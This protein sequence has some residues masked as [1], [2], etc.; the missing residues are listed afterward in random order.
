M[1]RT[2]RELTRL[3]KLTYLQSLQI[4]NGDRPAEDF[5]QIGINSSGLEAVLPEIKKKPGLQTLIQ[6]VIKTKFPYSPDPKRRRVTDTGWSIGRI[7]KE[8]FWDVVTYR[9]GVREVGLNSY[10]FAESS[11]VVTVP[12]ISPKPISKVVLKTEETIPS[13]YR[14]TKAWIKYHVSFDNG[15]TWHAINPMDKPS[16]FDAQGKVI[17]RVLTVGSSSAFV[18]AETANI[19]SEN[20][21]YQVRLKISMEGDNEVDNPERLSPILHSYQLLIYPRGGL[22]G[23]STGET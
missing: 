16:R 17:P 11:S 7:F 4:N 3:I 15:Q 9:I 22:T 19:P 1:A 8:I 23:S 20:D 6:N 12:A 2:I 13:A 18:N 14:A 5:L 10:E 21:V